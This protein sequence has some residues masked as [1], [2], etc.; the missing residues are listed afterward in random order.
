MSPA[1]L[2]PTARRPGRPPEPEP[3]PPPSP[4]Q[5]RS[6]APGQPVGRRAPAPWSRRAALRRCRRPRDREARGTSDF[7]L[8][9]RYI[10]DESR[11]GFDEVSETPPVLR[12]PASRTRPL[13]R[14]FTRASRENFLPYA[15]CPPFFEVRIR[16]WRPA[17]HSCC[18]NA[19]HASCRG[20]GASFG[21]APGSPGSVAGRQLA[22]LVHRRPASRPG[23]RRGRWGLGRGAASVAAPRRRQGFG[24]RAARQARA[25]AYTSSHSFRT[26]SRAFSW[27]GVPSN[28][29]RPWPIT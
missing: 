20:L 21:R 10:P 17:R 5:A 15:V 1:R 19:T 22:R 25:R 3:E 16:R 28:C 2:P 8:L 7:K 27:S 14:D 18:V 6:P 13:L 12:Q 4:S 11:L 23:P 24:G 26:S 29:I 9:F